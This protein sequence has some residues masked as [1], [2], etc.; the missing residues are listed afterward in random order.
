MIT[1][2]EGTV[3]ALFAAFCR[4]GGCIMIMPGFSSA[5]VPMQVRLFIAVAV[6]MAILPVMWTDIYPQVTGKGHSYIYLIAAETAVGAVM[7]LVARYYV[8]GLQFTGTAITM[9]MGFASPPSSDVIEDTPENQVTSLISFAGLMV[10]FMLDF[11]H[12]MIEA[13]VQSYRAMPI[14]T[15]FDPQ[16]VL[17][18][19]TDSLAQIFMIMLRLASP[20]IIY[21]LLFNVAIG[22]VNKL[23]PQ[24]PIYFISQP[25]LIMGGL[26]LLYLGIA[27]M[28]RLFGDGFALVMQ[29]G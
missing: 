15:P 8:L 6:S 28:L 29:G 27:A 2:P 22:M 11:H 25:Y 4:I 10:L 13:I 18:T 23:A 3:L 24:I 19:L 14:G 26:F 9:L 1:D 16:G 7:G 17:I 21:G 5:R 12:V 20:F